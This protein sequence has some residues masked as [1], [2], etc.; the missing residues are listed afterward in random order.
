[1]I[2]A[3]RGGASPLPFQ[4]LRRRFPGPKIECH[5]CDGER[6]TEMMMV[7]IMQCNT[8]KVFQLQSRYGIEWDAMQ[9]AM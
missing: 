1:M 8:S 6:P 9:W 3:F 7:V 2:P 4:W 5:G